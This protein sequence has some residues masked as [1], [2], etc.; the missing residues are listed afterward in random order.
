MILK[1]FSLFSKK[2]N[3][4]MVEK[5][6]ILFKTMIL[7]GDLNDITAYL[8]Q[9]NIISNKP[10]LASLKKNVANIYFLECLG[11]LIYHIYEYKQSKD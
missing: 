4:T 6:M 3:P 5:Y 10:I 11:W 7:L 8:I 9:L 2:G 1:E